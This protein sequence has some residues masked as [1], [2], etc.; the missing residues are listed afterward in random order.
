M[1]TAFYRYLW[2]ASDEKE[3]AAARLIAIVQARERADRLFGATLAHLKQL[4]PSR[5]TRAR[6]HVASQDALT[7][8]ETQVYA[9]VEAHCGWFDQYSLKFSSP[10]IDFCKELPAAQ[11][12][13][14]LRQFCRPEASVSA[15]LAV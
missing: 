15:R 10:L 9:A 12:Q 2:A 6:A 3:E 11:I 1:L 4:V 8:C 14:A 7:H 5:Y 13:A